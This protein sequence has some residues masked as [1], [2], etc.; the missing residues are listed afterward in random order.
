MA[1]VHSIVI[2]PETRHRALSSTVERTPLFNS[3]EHAVPDSDRTHR[4]EKLNPFWIASM[5]ADRPT[6]PDNQM[7][8]GKAL[9]QEVG[10][11]TRFDPGR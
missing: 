11:Q 1:G 7:A 6:A 9:N 3:G 8:H 5:R 2:K 4:G 10:L